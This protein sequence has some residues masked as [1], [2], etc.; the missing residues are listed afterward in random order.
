MQYAKIK[1]GY[2]FAYD[3]DNGYTFK[4]AKEQWTISNVNFDVVI[5]QNENVEFLDEK[6][7]IEMTGSTPKQTSEYLDKYLEGKEL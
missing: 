2:L 3:E 5:R 4:Y 7:V 1:N 6:E